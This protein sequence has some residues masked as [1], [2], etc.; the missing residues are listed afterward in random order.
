MCDLNNLECPACGTM[1]KVKGL[2]AEISQ[3]GP[4]TEVAQSGPDREATDADRKIIVSAL[5]KGTYDCHK[6]ARKTG[7]KAPQVRAIKAW[8][9]P[10][11]GDKKY[12]RKH[13]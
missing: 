10:S 2:H 8:C 6:L 11:L 7:L 5:V 13:S 4:G 1:L 12:I 3:S 9:S